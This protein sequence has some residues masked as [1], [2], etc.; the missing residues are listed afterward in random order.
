MTKPILPALVA[1]L[2]GV[3]GTGK[4]EICRILGA[5][6]AVVGHSAKSTTPDTIIYTVD[7]PTHTLKLVDTRGFADTEH[8]PNQATH[9]SILRKLHEHGID[10]IDVILW[11]NNYATR[12]EAGLQETAAYIK[13]YAENTDH[14]LHQNVV[15]MYRCARQTGTH[16]AVAAMEMVLG[17]GDGDNPAVPHHFMGLLP[18]TESE[19][20]YDKGEYTEADFRAELLE[21]VLAPR[22]PV[23]VVHSNKRCVDC[24][25]RGDPRLVE[26][27][28]HASMERAHD[29]APGQSH[30][31]KLEPRHSREAYR[32][33]ADLKKVHTSAPVPAHGSTQRVHGPA[34]P[35]HHSAERTHPGYETK[36]VPGQGFK[37]IFQGTGV[38]LPISAPVE[39]TKCIKC[40][41]KQGQGNLGAGCVYACCDGVRECRVQCQQCR[42]IVATISVDGAVVPIAADVGGCVLECC[43]QLPTAPA[44]AFKYGCC[45]QL[46]NNALALPC[47][48][49]CSK[50][51]ADP[52]N[53]DGC[54][55]SCCDTTDPAKGCIEE[56]SCC[57][58]GKDVTECVRTTYSGC[59]HGAV[60]L[61]CI[62]RCR[63]CKGT[64][65]SSK[66][67]RRFAP[68]TYVEIDDLDDLDDLDAAQEGSEGW[69]DVAAASSH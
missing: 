17:G 16:G 8:F 34:V 31:G 61:P 25:A 4:T 26:G 7:L 44:C 6:E 39:V 55:M 52:A 57:G 45:Q 1:L 58:L 69:E 20:N 21:I 22:T 68:H 37:V 60:D 35:V 47:T 41:A 63:M 30:T 50:C 12:A 19:S 66:G 42:S 38:E 64:K 5:K 28:C 29:G 48:D 11:C 46:V 3:T 62:D 43:G 14:D 40:G 9:T 32:I 18:D 15:V 33:H 56:W 23:R 27:G 13:S 54:K 51:G 67:C 53:S 2:V 10:S 49:V 59:E 65:G 24:T 36:V